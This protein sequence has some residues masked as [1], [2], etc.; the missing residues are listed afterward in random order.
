[1]VVKHFALLLATSRI[2]QGTKTFLLYKPTNCGYYLSA[3]CCPQPLLRDRKGTWSR[4]MTPWWYEWWWWWWWWWKWWLWCWYMPMMIM[5]MITMARMV[6][7]LLSQRL[8][9]ASPCTFQPNST[10]CSCYPSPCSPT[11]PSNKDLLIETWH[12]CFKVLHSKCIF[13]GPIFQFH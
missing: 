1:M 4:S 9:Q 8:N 12:I 10:P 6:T 5:L 13:K 2:P 3:H 7:I 11:P